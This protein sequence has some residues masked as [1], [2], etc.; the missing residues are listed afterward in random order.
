MLAKKFDCKTEEPRL[1]AQ[2]EEQGIYRFDPAKGQPVHAIDTPPPTVSGKLH[3]GH[4]YSYCQTDFTARFQRMRGRAVFY[5]M[6]FDDNGLPT[7]QLVERQVGRRAEDMEIAQ[8]RAHCLEVSQKAAE[9]YRALWR[10]LGLSVDWTHTYRT[11]EAVGLA[12]WAFVD[13]YE[14]DLVYRREAPVIWCPACATAMAQADLEEVERDSV[15]YTLAFSLENGDALPI[16]TTRPELL[17]AC[18]AVFVHPD[19][20]R[21]AHLVG[22]PG[23][24]AA[25]QQDCGGAGRCW[26]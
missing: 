25:E 24:T 7:E 14:K 12:Q 18:V 6:G 19:D 16:A 11:I 3:M 2:W 22:R 9:E 4:V 5:P 23:V 17:P 8:F 21:F 10:E 26:C 20:T 15:M 13:L 1:R